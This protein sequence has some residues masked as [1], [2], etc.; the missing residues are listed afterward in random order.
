MMTGM[1]N[2]TI[3]HSLLLPSSSL[4]PPS[5]T[6]VVPEESVSRNGVPT[7]M[8]VLRF[9]LKRVEEGPTEVSNVC[10]VLNFV[11]FTPL[12]IPLLVLAVL[13]LLD[14]EQL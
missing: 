2:S 8:N 4:S 14:S 5:P 1:K 13:Q 9:R 3:A 10:I 6:K 7:T 12:R 11:R